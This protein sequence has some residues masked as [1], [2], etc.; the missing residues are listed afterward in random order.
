M[1]DIVDNTP[2][3]SI[4]TLVLTGP[5]GVGKTTVANAISDILREAE[6]A[7]A[8]I[9]L[10]SL[11]WCHPSPPSDP[12]HMALGLRNLA[13]I[14]P[15]YHSAGAQRLVLADIVETRSAL[16]GYQHALPGAAIQIVRLQATLPTILRRLQGREV[17]ASLA[18]HR[19][20]A[21]ELVAQMDARKVEDVLVQTDDKTIASIAREVLMRTAWIGGAG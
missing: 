10:D 13:A 8:C 6:I 15:N 4:P 9:D 16:A 7:H 11:R 14:W 19:R 18:W 12:F 2:A 3:L 1:R 20:R 5:V 21:A 17:G